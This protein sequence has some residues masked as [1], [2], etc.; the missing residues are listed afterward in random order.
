MADQLKRK[1]VDSKEFG[2]AVLEQVNKM[3]TALYPRMLR[4]SVSIGLVFKVQF[5]DPDGGTGTC[6]CT[7][8]CAQ[9]SDGTVTCIDICRCTPN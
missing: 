3:R 8:Q 6:I 9:N 7:T 5:D 4:G 2:E 1:I